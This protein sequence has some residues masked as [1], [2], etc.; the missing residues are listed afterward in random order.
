[1]AVEKR[2]PSVWYGMLCQLLV[3]QRNKESQLCE[4]GKINKVQPEKNQASLCSFSSSQGCFCFVK[5]DS[6]LTLI[7]LHKD[8]LLCSY[9]PLFF[10]A[11]TSLFLED[12][13]KLLTKL[14]VKPEN[15][16]RLPSFKG[17]AGNRRYKLILQILLRKISLKEVVIWL[18]IKILHIQPNAGKN[19]QRLHL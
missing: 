5:P 9:S 11:L 19:Y 4:K 1:M 18:D 14:P 2:V 16:Y 12:A 3:R 6:I 15:Y 17:F 13:S 10:Q 7:Q 8:Q